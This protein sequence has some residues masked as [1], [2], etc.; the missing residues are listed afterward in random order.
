MANLH[1]ATDD[2]EMPLHTKLLS[3]WPNAALEILPC[4]WRS[5]LKSHEEAACVLS[6][7]RKIRILEM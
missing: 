5:N 7:T 6:R 2:V 3:D 1:F 4:H